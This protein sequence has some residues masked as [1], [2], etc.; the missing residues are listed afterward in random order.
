MYNNLATV[1]VGIV[2]DEGDM[3][4]NQTNARK[5]K[6]VAG[7]TPRLLNCGTS[8]TL[9]SRVDRKDF[10]VQGFGPKPVNQ[11]CSH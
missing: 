9:P 3:R 5:R 6:K 4:I 1:L 8:L 7:S 11:G 10:I 2:A